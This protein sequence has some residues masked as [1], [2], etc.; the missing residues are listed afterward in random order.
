MMRVCRARVRRYLEYQALAQGT[1]RK[2]LA[3]VPVLRTCGR[4]GSERLQFDVAGRSLLIVFEGS[5]QP[6]GVPD[7]SRTEL[8]RP[9]LKTCLILVA[10]ALLCLA[11]PVGSQQPLVGLI[12]GTVKNQQGAPVPNASVTATNLDTIE[13]E[14]QASGTNSGGTFQIVDVPP[15]HYSIAVTNKDYQDNLL[16]FVTVHDGQTVNI[17]IKMKR[18]DAEKLGA[19]SPD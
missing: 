13:R 6:V 4:L 14:W 16:P 10:F 18:K 9:R 1:A 17:T 19:I 5:Q 2:V 3:E 12:Q 15:G 7:W 11:F 8:R